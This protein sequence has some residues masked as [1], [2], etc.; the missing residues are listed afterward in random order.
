MSWYLGSVSETS[1]YVTG[2]LWVSDAVNIS[3]HILPSDLRY[4]SPT[5]SHKHTV[6]MCPYLWE[7]FPCLCV[8]VIS[9]SALPDF[10]VFTDK[11]AVKQ[12]LVDCREINIFFCSVLLCRTQ[13]QWKYSWTGRPFMSQSAE[14][15]INR[16][17]EYVLIFSRVM[18]F[19]Q[20]SVKHRQCSAS[21]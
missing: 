12:Q 18:V 6:W 20:I 8:V 2:L 5:Y 17:F 7:M 4:K 3:L 16:H 9:R 11:E 1:F 15:Y 14:V 10:S 21:L 19:L 13:N